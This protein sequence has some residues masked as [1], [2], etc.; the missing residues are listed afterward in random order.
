[1]SEPTET[2]AAPL[3]IAQVIELCLLVEME[4]RWENLRKERSHTPQ[5]RP[6]TAEDLNGVQR[7]YEAFRT[8]LLAY[9]KKYTPAHVTDLLLNYP[10]RLGPWCRRMR[11]LYR[12]VEQNPRISCPVHLLDKAYRWADGIAGRMSKESFSRSTSLTTIQA[13]LGELEALARWCDA[14]NA[15]AA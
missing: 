12:Q 13:A 14:L 3:P 15:I 11:D 9:N 2:P 1:M 4:A 6:Q 10:N 5:L 7:A 8:K